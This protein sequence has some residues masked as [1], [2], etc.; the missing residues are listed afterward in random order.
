MCIRL[1]EGN[2]L[3]SFVCGATA[4]AEEVVAIASF[5]HCPIDAASF[6][7]EE[8]IFCIPCNAYF[9][10]VGTVISV[11][12]VAFQIIYDFFKTLFCNENLSPEAVELTQNLKI[13]RA[14]ISEL[15]PPLDI[16]QLLELPDIDVNE[17]LTH[18]DTLFAETR[19][20]DRF[21]ILGYIAYVQARSN[22]QIVRDLNIVAAAKNL[23]FEL[24]K[25]EIPRVKKETALIEIAFAFRNCEPRIYEDTM[26]QLKNLTNRFRT[27][28]QQLPFWHQ[29]FKEDLI[30]ENYQVCEFHVIN[31]A[32]RHVPDWGLDRDGVNL[33]D[34][35]QNIGGM[36]NGAL[37]YRYTLNKDYNLPRAIEAIR[38][39]FI[40]EG[41]NDL[42][43]DYLARH[44]LPD[45]FDFRDFFERDGT[46]ISY[47]AVVWIHE[48]ERFLIPN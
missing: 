11:A 5:Q 33:S 6:A 4:L 15:P 1:A 18:F 41:S 48:Q 35:F 21:S 29:L 32:R 46:T 14:K 37:N 36:F 9:T 8:A 45:D 28:E 38:N 31:H 42:I 34:P 30:I 25:P 39:R 16:Y 3:N 20:G 17:L 13:N 26:R 40:G 44:P 2:P 47:R 43:N 12:T 22:S 23:V 27:L 10:V 7:D 19:P 24:R